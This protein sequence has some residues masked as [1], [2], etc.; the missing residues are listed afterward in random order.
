MTAYRNLTF[1][2]LDLGATTC[3]QRALTQTEI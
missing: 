2:E 1:D 3:V